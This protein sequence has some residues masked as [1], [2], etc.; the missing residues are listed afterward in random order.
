MTSPA[1]VLLV[2][3]KSSLSFDEVQKVVDERIDDFRALMGLQQKYY[4]Q[5]PATGEV[6]GLYIWESQDDFL[7]YRDSELRAS[8]A[9]AYQTEGEPQIQVLSVFKTLR[10]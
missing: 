1:L 5:D 8:I 9:E 4:V 7:E 2:K 10:D 6:G 3:F